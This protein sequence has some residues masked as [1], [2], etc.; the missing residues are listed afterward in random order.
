VHER[1]LREAR[2]AV[3]L[4]SEHV[5][6]VIDVGTLESGA[7]YMVMELLQGRDLGALI[8]T[9]PKIFVEDAVEY[10][11]QTCEAIGEA[12]AAGIIHRDLKPANLFLTKT[13]G[14]LPCIKVLDFGVS[15]HTGADI[16]LTKESEAL[17][18][19]LYM[20][21]EQ[22]QAS[23]DVDARSDIWALGVILYELL[24]STTP[25][26]AE[27]MPQLCTRIFMGEPTPIDSLRSGVPSGLWA[28]IR[29]CIEKDRERRFRNVAELAAALAP[30]APSRAVPYV[31]R[32]ATILG[33]DVSP[34]RSTDD[35]PE[36]SSAPLVP[37]APPVAPA[38]SA[39]RGL[40]TVVS[41]PT[42]RTPAS[43]AAMISV[44]TLVLLAAATGIAWLVRA[45]AALPPPGATTLPSSVTP[46]LPSVPPTST[47]TATPSST[48]TITPSAAET[49]VPRTSA[50]PSPSAPS[51]NKAP[52][53]GYGGPRK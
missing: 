32:T 11:L 29:Q 21:P 16:A 26:H 1:F 44:L 43:A 48:P 45:P 40:T 3:R 51:S 6:R 23:K 49:A 35:L 22:M 34:A 8:K 12:H 46:P 13:P 4:K 24:A 36:Q 41:R 14:G 27:G 52:A 38:V 37:I 15:K 30:Y 42:T 19:P 53:S 7:P 10:V 31:E 25:F 17:G 9:E 33:V 28:V 5:A 50:R 47:A 39:D 18:S 2:A 20:S